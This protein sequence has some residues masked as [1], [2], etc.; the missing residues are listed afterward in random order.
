MKVSIAYHIVKFGK[1][2]KYT[3]TDMI[4]V[5]ILPELFCYKMGGKTNKQTN[6]SSFPVN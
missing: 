6:K 5:V 3:K 2:V 4:L 1:I